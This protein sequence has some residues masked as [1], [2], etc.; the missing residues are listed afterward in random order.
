L[1]GL[2]LNETR[3]ET[4]SPVKIEYFSQEPGLYYEQIGELNLIEATWKLVIKLDIT[5]INIRYKR[6]KECIKETNDLCKEIYNKTSETLC[7]NM[8]LIIEKNTDQLNYALKQINSIYKRPTNKRR[9]LI[10]GIG[11]IAKTLFGTMDADDEKHINEQLTVIKN[12]EQIIQHTIKTQL[13]ILNTTVTYVNKLEDTLEYNHEILRNT[14]KR[15]YNQ[16]MIEIKKED[17][18]EHFLIINAIISDLQKDLQD[19]SNFLIHI[20]K[21]TIDPRLIPLEK[22]ITELREIT[23]QLPQGTQL[24]FGL[25]IEEWN[26]IEK[27]ITASAYYDN[28]NIFIILRFPLITFPKYQII[29]IIPFPVHN[30]DNIF[31]F[32]EV[33]QHIIM[34]NTD[35]P[36]YMTMTK[37]NLDECINIYNTYLCEPQ[38]PTYVIN[39]KSPC[40]IQTYTH[41]SKNTNTCNKRYINSNQTIWIK[42]ST[43]NSWLYSTPIEQQISIQCK[44]K[45]KTTAIIKRTGR[46]TLEENCK[47]ITTDMTI[48]TIKSIPNAVIQTYLPNFNLTFNKNRKLR[49]NKN[50]IEGLKFEKII[51]DPKELMDL[52]TQIEEINK[53]Q[54]H[55][56]QNP[57][58]E[59]TF[60]YPMT[61]SSIAVVIAIILAIILV[62]K[63]WKE[64]NPF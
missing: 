35:G 24:P 23:P 44:N 54:E 30:H 6:I 28:A 41:I 7:Q 32:T 61:T 31:I 26:K 63:I 58:M 52:S 16:L 14:T 42:L 18:L 37:E 17:I 27:F 49:N 8:N 13:K 53:L 33:N 59:K 64:Q 20:Q 10:N 3:T 43:P 40:E 60:I 45:Q 34:V 15:V 11:N 29:K 38:S 39:I 55:N 5:T 19:I 36:T 62:L 12:N 1:L 47:V 4:I 9:G 25:N 48:K 57:F 21:G 50:M 56:F 22:I 51:Q 2:N 46:I